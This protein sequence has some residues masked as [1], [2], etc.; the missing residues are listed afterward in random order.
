MHIKLLLPLLPLLAAATA[1]T[2]GGY[3][4]PKDIA[5]GFYT[6]DFHDDGT[7]TTTRV[8]FDDT[9]PTSSPPETRS[10]LGADSAKFAR[11]LTRRVTWGSTNRV[12]SEQAQYNS[13]TDRWKN[14]FAKGNGVGSQR[15]SYFTTDRL[16]L[17]CCNY[18]NWELPLPPQA[19]DDF[20]RLLDQ[21]LGSWRTGWA[22]F[23]G[24]YGDV[25]FWRDH[26]GVQI[27]GNLKGGV[28]PK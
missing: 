17:A 20:N 16:V 27:C 11:Q 18:Q 8:D 21:Q 28:V 6:V 5:P 13:L 10:L 4:V 1:V 9:P 12:M 25:S 15:I 7:T 24:V 2:E 26:R 3:I 14:W 22:H 19:V 23:G